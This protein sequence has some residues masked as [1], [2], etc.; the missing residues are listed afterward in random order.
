[1]TAG[2]MKMRFEGTDGHVRLVSALKAQRLILGN[3]ELANRLA[4]LGVLVEAAKGE[5]IIMQGATNNDVFFIIA[6]EFQVVINHSKVA[7]R[8]NT[9]CVGEMSAIEGAYSRSASIIAAL[10]HSVALK[11]SAVDFNQAVVDYPHM[12][13]DIN[14]QLIRRLYQRN[15][16]VRPSNTKPKLFVISSAEALNV[17]DQID[18]N[19]SHYDREFE[20]VRWNHS[21][22]GPAA[23][24]LESLE[25]QL[26]C[27]DFAIAVA[28]PDD[29]VNTR[30]V[31]QNAARDNVI[32]EYGM[33]LGRLGRARAFLLLPKVDTPILPSDLKGVTPL[34]YSIN[35]DGEPVVTPACAALRK[36][37]NLHGPR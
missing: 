34:Q 16:L 18:I 12:L 9:E 8:G 30:G 31:T 27:C 14:R 17:V 26:D 23:Y 25:E 35:G 6:G 37:I 29:T 10:E 2:Q 22:F 32:L 15:D 13:I 11:V 21:V 19:L 36:A 5:A 20:V 7:T 1:M 28:Q 24:T 4:D 33:F 3:D